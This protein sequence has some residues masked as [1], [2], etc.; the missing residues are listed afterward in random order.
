M[1][2]GIAGNSR[3]KA[4]QNISIAVYLLTLILSFLPEFINAEKHE[5][6]E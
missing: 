4:T 5:Y 2:S 1:F 3:I 6:L